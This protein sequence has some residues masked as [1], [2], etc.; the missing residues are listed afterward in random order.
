[1]MNKDTIGAH[2]R[3]GLCII[4]WGSLRALTAHIGSAP[5]IKQVLRI[6]FWSAIAMGCT[7]LINSIFGIQNHNFA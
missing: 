1:M 4:L 2:A 7:A 6:A 5:I 3:S